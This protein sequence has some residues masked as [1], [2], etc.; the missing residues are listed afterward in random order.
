MVRSRYYRLSL[1][2]FISMRLG[3]KFCSFIGLQYFR[4]VAEVNA[5]SGSVVNWTG[6]RE[7]VEASMC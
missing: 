4:L 7:L 6:Y 5:R 2:S 3:S 1:L